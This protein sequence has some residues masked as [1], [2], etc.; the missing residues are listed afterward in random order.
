MWCWVVQIGA[1]LFSCL[2]LVFL[3]SHTTSTAFSSSIEAG[4]K[5]QNVFSMYICLFVCLDKSCSGII[6]VTAW[7]E[8]MDELLTWEMLG[9]MTSYSRL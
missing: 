2:I 3:T 9:C 7:L 1:S 5:K 6:Q 8:G 4:P